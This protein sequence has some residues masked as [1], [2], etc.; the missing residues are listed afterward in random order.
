MDVS[1]TA[2]YSVGFLGVFTMF[3][4]FAY[5]TTDL[6][7]AD[8]PVAAFVYAGISVVVGLAASAVGY[9]AGRALV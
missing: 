5:E 2:I 6:L 7:R 4:T 3:S 9:V 1:T 8:R